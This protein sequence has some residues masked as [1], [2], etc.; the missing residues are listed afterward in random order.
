VCND[1]LHFLLVVVR[2]VFTC[3]MHC[4]AAFA[5]AQ[6]G[7]VVEERVNDGTVKSGYPYINI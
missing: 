6:I 1:T 7:Y 4:A 3:T 2:H 5:M